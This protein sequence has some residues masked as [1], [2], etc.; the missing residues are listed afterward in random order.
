[1]TRKR[2][3]VLISGRGSNLQSLIDAARHPD[4]PAKIVVVIS[5]VPSAQGLLRAEADFIPGVTIN[6]KEFPSREAF[7]QA[8]D[9]CAERR[10]RRAPL[11][12]RLSATA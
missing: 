10:R 5:N 12:R 11:Q 3:G 6:H 9:D 8:L 7:D 4:Y 2:V 1:M